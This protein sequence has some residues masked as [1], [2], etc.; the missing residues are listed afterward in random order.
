M[1]ARRR[2]WLVMLRSRTLNAGAAGGDGGDAGARSVKQ[3]SG[4]GDEK[5]G[6]D[7][8]AEMVFRN[9]VSFL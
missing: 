1:K 9:V 5:E 8:F 7:L 4:S 2:G 6:F 3:R